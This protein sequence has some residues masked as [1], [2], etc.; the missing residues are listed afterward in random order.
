[1]I[2]TL[3]KDGS[4]LVYNRMFPRTR[5]I[6]PVKVNKVYDTTGC[7]D[8][9]AAG[10]LTEYIKTKSYIKAG[11]QANNMAASRCRVKGKM[12]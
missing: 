12:F 7:G 4:L 8:T 1:M 10:F 3:G 9:F 6:A 5:K 11:K 2:I